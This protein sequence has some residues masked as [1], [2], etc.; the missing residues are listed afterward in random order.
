MTEPG[1]DLD[2]V[3]VDFNAGD[4]VRACVESLRAHPPVTARLGEVVVVD[5][6]S[7]T[8]THEY[9]EGMC[10]PVRVLRNDVNRGFAAACNQR[11][12]EG[13]APYILFLNP[14]TRLL[15]GSLDQPVGFMADPVNAGVGIVGIRLLGE[16]GS[17]S[18]SC[19]AF[20]QVRHYLHKALGLDRIAPRLFPS[21]A[22]ATWAHNETRDVDQVMGAFFLVRRQLFERLSGFDERFFVYFEEV[23]FALRASQ[24]GYASRFLANVSAVHSGHGTTD[25]IR[26]T[27]L[28]LILESRLRYARKHFS[29]A[30]QLA[31]FGTTLLM[32]PLSRA[33]V[34]LARRRP[35]ELGELRRAYV[36]VW[37]RLAGII[38]G[39]R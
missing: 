30:Q 16:D 15:P 7:R 26:A 4:L 20:P 23:D 3:I 5:N 34:A 25:S 17:T 35:H 9:V 1:A 39:V 38:R 12:R 11:A 27:R 22:M 33:A 37:R 8:P 13:Q 19:F 29:L 2:I 36:G 21:G 14:D 24:A 18:T 32:E 28:L 10:P 31:L 6:A